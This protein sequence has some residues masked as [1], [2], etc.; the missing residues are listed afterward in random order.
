MTTESRRERC[1]QSEINTQ[2]LSHKINIKQRIDIIQKACIVS[3]NGL[4]IIKSGINSINNIPNEIDSSKLPELEEFCLKYILPTEEMNG[5]TT[6]I[7]HDHFKKQL[8]L[9]L[10]DNFDSLK[11]ILELI[12]YPEHENYRFNPER[13][14]TQCI[15]V[16]IDDLKELMSNNHLFN[17]SPKNL[18]LSGYNE[19]YYINNV[20][21]IKVFGKG[22]TYVM[23][24]IARLIKV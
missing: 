20:R 17:H 6:K 5:D 15:D 7:I 9:S 12:N 18:R 11:N 19:N 21:D 4:E 14:W 2:I 22:I 3:L 10:K 8:V 13:D 24:E 1:T 23:R 16:A